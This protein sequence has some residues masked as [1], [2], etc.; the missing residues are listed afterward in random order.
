MMPQSSVLAG[1]TDKKSSNLYYFGRETG[2]N[3][4]CLI[5]HTQNLKNETDFAF[6][7]SKS[8]W[9]MEM[10]SMMKILARHDST[11]NMTKSELVSVDDNGAMDF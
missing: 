8:Q 6:R 9:W 2:L 5:F 10:R 7:R 11:Y 3:N 4:P 1:T